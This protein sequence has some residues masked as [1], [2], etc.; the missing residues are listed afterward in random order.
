MKSN[1]EK[2]QEFNETFD[3][4]VR[5]KPGLH[6]KDVKMRRDIWKE[7]TEEI[8]DAFAKFEFLD[9]VYNVLVEQGVFQAKIRVIMDALLEKV[10]V[11]FLDGL[12]DTEVTLHGLAQATGMPTPAGYQVVHASN[13]SKI[14]PDGTILRRA[15]GKIQKGDNYFPPTPVLEKLI[16]EA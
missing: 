15:D 2:T 14:Q 13:M 11:E 1:F 4:P 3:V 10:N 9:E 12:I 16:R 8:N 5:T 6:Y 7:E